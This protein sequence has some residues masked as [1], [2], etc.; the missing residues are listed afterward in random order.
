MQNLPIGIQD[1]SELRMRNCVYVDK[2]KLIFQLA[3]EGKYYFFSRPRRFGKSLLVSVLKYLYLGQKELFTDT[4]IYNKWDWTKNNPVI[5]ISFDAVSYRNGLEE[6]LRLTLDQQATIYNITLTLTE[7]KPKF[8]ELITKLYERYGKVVLLIDEYD[9]PII[10]YLEH[11]KI[12]I[13]KQNREVMREFYS[14]LKNADN[15]LELL[16]ITGISKFAQVS[17]FS[18]LNNLSDI[19]LN[20]DYSTLLGYTQ[21]ELEIFFK[22]YLLKTSEELDLPQE[23]LLK[24]MKIR[25]NGYSWDGKKQVYNPFG[26]L[27][28]FQERAFHNFWFSTGS[29]NF[30]IEQMK[31]NARFDIENLEIRNIVLEKFDI[32][33]LD[34]VPLFFQAGYLTVKKSNPLTGTLLLDYPNKEV[35]ECMY[36]YLL[37]DL[38]KNPYRLNQGITMRDICKSL[39]ENDLENVIQILNSILADLPS[40]TFK[41]QTEG[42]YHGLLHIIFSYLGMFIQSEVHSSRGRADVV[43]QTDSH[44]YIFEFKFNKS[45]QEALAQIQRQKYGEKYKTNNKIITAIGV[46]FS[47][48]NKQIDEWQTLILNY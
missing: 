28:F 36:E 14:I 27:R 29:P 22:S 45:A 38:A 2:T 34:L 4:W 16:F 8:Q 26:V 40:E 17:I 3:C 44:V 32:E 41:K 12:D 5:H 39:I 25:Y 11:N 1:F 18:A 47:E 7:A 15:M 33:N 37:D 46:N 21:E 19:T 43:I 48:A 23:E 24:T 6:G 42:L 9:K 35:Q 10:D 13:A 30:L 31:K 20:K